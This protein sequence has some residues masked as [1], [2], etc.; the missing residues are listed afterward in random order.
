VTATKFQDLINTL[1]EHDLL[2]G[3]LQ[4]KVHKA[5]EEIDELESMG[6]ELLERESG[7]GWCKKDYRF[8][9]NW[10][11]K[12]G[13]TVTTQDNMVIGGIADYCPMCGKW[14]GK[15]GKVTIQKGLRHA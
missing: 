2:D 7:C 11:D 5:Q 1:L 9:F 3:F 6:K 8:E 13:S 12:E 14:V 10:V 15:K 4:D